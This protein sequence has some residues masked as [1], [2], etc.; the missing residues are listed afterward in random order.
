MIHNGCGGIPPLAPHVSAWSQISSPQRDGSTVS[1]QLVSRIIRGSSFLP[2]GGDEK[3]SPS[4][5]H[6]VS[7]MGKGHLCLLS[8]G[9]TSR[10]LS[11]VLRRGTLV[12]GLGCSGSEGLPPLSPSLLGPPLYTAM[13]HSGAL[14]THTFG[15]L[16]WEIRQIWS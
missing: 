2:W 7:Q 15:C 3:T 9:E 10:S 8:R 6:Y 1:H 12:L 16:W 14:L 5:I 11:R 13:N 4:I